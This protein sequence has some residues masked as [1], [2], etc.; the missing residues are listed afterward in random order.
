MEPQMM[1]VGLTGGIG[2][3]KSFVAD[4]FAALG[5]P[6]ID[7]DDINRAITR[8]GQP[9]Y[10][11]IVQQFGQDV[12]GADGELD[13]R[14]IRNIIFEDIAERRALEAILHPA[15]YQASLEAI[16]QQNAPYVIVVVPLLFEHDNFK[17]IIHRSLVVDCPVNLQLERVC[18]RDGLT[19]LQA[20][21]IIDAQMDR[22]QRVALAD[23]VIVNDGDESSLKLRVQALHTEYLK[24]CTKHFVKS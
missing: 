2:S 24:A 3:G 9:C 13:R 22:A 19:T 23:D 20:Q 7:V 5:V 21:H 14:E 4:L 17:S 8:R 18:Q 16:Q 10:Q 1:V 6:I 15:I 11:A 12:V